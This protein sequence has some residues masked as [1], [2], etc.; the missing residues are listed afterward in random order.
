[1]RPAYP[2]VVEVI[3]A[4]RPGARIEPVRRA[5]EAAGGSIGPL[6]PGAA[7]AES[8]RWYLVAHRKGASKAGVDSL[9]TELRSLSEVDA[10]YVKPPGEPP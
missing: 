5:V 8:Q 7:D 3:V 2:R 1:M 10:A 6:Y 4:I 9:L